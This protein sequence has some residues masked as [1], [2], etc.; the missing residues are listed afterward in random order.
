MLCNDI[1]S[2][3]IDDLIALQSFIDVIFLQF[4]LLRLLH[5]FLLFQLIL[6]V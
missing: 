1:D 4:S 5:F 6:D 3:A 2:V